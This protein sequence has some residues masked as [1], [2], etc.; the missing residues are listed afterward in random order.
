MADQSAKSQHSYAYNDSIASIDSMATLTI[1]DF[2]D[3]L[4]QSL[5]V[6]AAQNGRSME[7]EV[8]IILEQAL[9]ATADSS[10]PER[11]N[12]VI[13]LYDLAC[14]MGGVE[15]DIPSRHMYNADER[16]PDFSDHTSA[17]EDLS[18]PA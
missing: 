8:R 18:A 11:N 10:T 14:R 7:S 6:R 3:N 5:R 17:S 16:V 2:D 15:L 13:D 9:T 1:R 12:W 4:K